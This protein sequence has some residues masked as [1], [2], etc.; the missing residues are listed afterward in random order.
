MAI[1]VLVNKFHIFI[2][3]DDSILSVSAYDASW[4][5]MIISGFFFT[6][7]SLAFVRAMS[8]PPM[9]PIF[10]WYH[11]STD[12]LF[13]S[14]MFTLATAPAVPYR[15]AHSSA[16]SFSSCTIQLQT[17]RFHPFIFICICLS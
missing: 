7:G 6:I 9:K 11:L 12:E 14:W 3:E 15:C 16:L 1:I 2:G 10:S 5:L 8:D 17:S 4:I 13:G